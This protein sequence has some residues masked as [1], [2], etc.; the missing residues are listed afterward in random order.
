[1]PK[2]YTKIVVTTKNKEYHGLYNDPTTT[3]IHYNIVVSCWKHEKFVEMGTNNGRV[4]ILSS[5][6]ES[7]EIK[8]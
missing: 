3:R 2:I 6:I 7:V 5:I 4:T 8:N 1:M